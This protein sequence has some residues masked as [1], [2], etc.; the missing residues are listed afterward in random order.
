MASRGLFVTGTDT[1]IGKT[2]TVLGLL[3][4]LRQRGIRVRGMKPVATGCRRTAAGLRSDDAL[5]VLAQIP[6]DLPYEWINPYAFEPPIAPACAARAAGLRI[7]LTRLLAIESRLAQG[8]DF[9]VI[10]GIGGW[11]VPLG[12]GACVS[13]LATRLGYPVVLVVGLRL[14]CINHALLSAEGIARDGAELAGWVAVQIDPQYASL[15]GTLATLA[16][17]IPAARLGFIP[18]LERPDPQAIG[19]HLETGLASIAG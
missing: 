15:E 12:P 10:E 5:A 2:L 4:G 3:A 8:A 13:D 19:S 18:F 6:E 14:G 11:R 1:G 9:M 17:R 7:S 16:A